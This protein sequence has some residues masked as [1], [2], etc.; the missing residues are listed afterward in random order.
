MAW[1][2]VAALIILGVGILGYALSLTFLLRFRRWMGQRGAG[3]P[4]LLLSTMLVR[5]TL[6]ALLYLSSLAS[7]LGLVDQRLGLVLGFLAGIILSVAPWVLV[8]ALYRWWP[9]GLVVLPKRRGR[10]DEPEGQ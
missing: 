2:E 9:D 3:W 7:T 6:L 10:P 4:R 8:L 5:E 1:M